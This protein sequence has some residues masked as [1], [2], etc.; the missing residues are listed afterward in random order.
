MMHDWKTSGPPPELLAAYAD[1]ALAGADYERVANWLADHPEAQTEVAELR[2]LQD[3]VERTQPREPDSASWAGV[4]DRVHTALTPPVRPSL[5]RRWPLAPYLGGAAAALLVVGLTRILW[6][7]RPVTPNPDSAAQIADLQS[8]LGS[9]EGRAASAEQ[10]AHEAERKAAEASARADEATCWAR[11]ADD[12][13]SEA[14]RRAEASSLDMASTP[15]LD[16]LSHDQVRLLNP[17]STIR[18]DDWNTPMVVDPVL[19]G[20][21]P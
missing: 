16:L 15:H 8:R 3:L 14:E 12:R 11:Q 4:L 18:P 20:R 13:T 17:S 5:R 19:S 7:E 9:V 21:A 1:G 10:R 6:G 2:R